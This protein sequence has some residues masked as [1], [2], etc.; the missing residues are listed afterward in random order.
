V[1]KTQFGHQ[2]HILPVTVH[3]VT[4][5]TAIAAVFDSSRLLAKVIPDAGHLAITVSRPFDLKG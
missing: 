5:H 3:M 1:P 2:G 4:G